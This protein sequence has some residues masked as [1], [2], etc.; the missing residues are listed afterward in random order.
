MIVVDT[1]VIA[2]S[3]RKAPDARV[4]TWLSR[5]DGAIALST[6][7]IAEIAS[8][9]ERIR[10][11]ERSPLLW[12]QLEARRNRFADRILPFDELSP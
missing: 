7:V 5:N 12:K 8:G 4:I 11:K 6:I 2:E 10:E 3:M 1:K 9:I